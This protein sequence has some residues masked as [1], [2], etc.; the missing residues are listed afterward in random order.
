MRLHVYVKAYLSCK[1]TG[2]LNVC[3]TCIFVGFLRGCT[4]FQGHLRIM[5]GAILHS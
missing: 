2:F 5:H 4:R 1:I 3:M